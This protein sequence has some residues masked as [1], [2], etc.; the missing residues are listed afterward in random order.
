M[1]TPNKSSTNLSMLYTPQRQKN[2]FAPL[3]SIAIKVTFALFTLILL[4][5]P[6]FFFIFKNIS[7]LAYYAVY[8]LLLTLGL[9]LRFRKKEYL[10]GLVTIVGVYAVVFWI[11]ILSN[12][13][14]TSHLM[15]WI[16]SLLP[17]VLFTDRQKVGLVVTALLPIV[18]S[19]FI[20]E[21]NLPKS[22]LV[23]AEQDFVRRL[24]YISVAVGAFACIFFQRQSLSAIEHAR[25]EENDFLVTAFETIPFPILV[26]DGITLEIISFN[27]AAKDIF[28][29]SPEKTYSNTDIFT[30]RSAAAVSVLDNETMQSMAYHVEEKEHL[31]SISGMHLYLRSSRI[32]LILKKSGRRLLFWVFELRD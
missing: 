1:R 9:Y 8:P 22:P 29:L 2:L 30:A 17:W 20:G 21:I 27:S 10:S 12:I 13:Q 16:I 25:A 6:S 7:L 24:L 3:D 32:P 18:F 31:E 11:S 28:G 23:P 19:F 14:Q 4:A 26:K 15:W 5:I